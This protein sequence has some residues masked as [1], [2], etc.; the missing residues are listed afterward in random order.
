MLC[1][2]TCECELCEMLTTES[3]KIIDYSD[4]HSESFHYE[5]KFKCLYTGL[6]A[7]TTKELKNME[8]KNV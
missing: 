3:V 8:E 1:P 5:H 6:L 4:I 7:N 2:K